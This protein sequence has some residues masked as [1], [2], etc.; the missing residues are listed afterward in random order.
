MVCSNF[1]A[2]PCWEESDMGTNW[3]YTQYRQHNG[4]GLLIGIHNNADSQDLKVYW[5]LP[6]TIK[7]L[8][9]ITLLYL[10][11]ST[12]GDYNARPASFLVYWRLWPQMTPR[13]PLSCYHMCA[14][15]PISFFCGIPW[16]SIK[17]CGYS[18]QVS[19]PLG[20]LPQMIPRWPLTPFL[21]GSYVCLYSPICCKIHIL[22]THPQCSFHSPF[23]SWWQ[24]Q[25]G[26]SYFR[27]HDTFVNS[28]IISTCF[29][30]W[31]GVLGAHLSWMPFRDV[32]PTFYLPL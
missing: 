19:W 24:G 10:K 3:N 27:K 28:I 4:I 9:R 15:T 18:D 11:T 26:I 30:F 22:P 8:S 25:K 29:F 7:L 14:H 20:Q 5:K 13:C 6:Q 12:C 32:S 16:K 23:F 21:L 31:P 1:L 17:V 2:W